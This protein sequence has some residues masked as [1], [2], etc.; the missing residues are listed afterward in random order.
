MIPPICP[1]NVDD[2]SLDAIA[3]RSSNLL[4]KPLISLPS[5]LFISDP[6]PF[7]HK[8]TDEE[9]VDRFL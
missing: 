9:P 8:K 3:P 2:A 4:G 5:T 6:P 1:Q 7:D